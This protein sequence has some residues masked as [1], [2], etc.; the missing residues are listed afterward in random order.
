MANYATAVL[1]KGQTLVS[2]KYQDPENRRKNPTVFEMSLRNYEASIT[3]ANDLRNAPTRPV[4]ISYQ[5]NIAAGNATAKAALHT[6]NYGDANK[7]TLVYITHVETFQIPAKLADGNF[8][9][10]QQMFNNMYEMHWKNLRTRQDSSALAYLISN[11]CQ[12]DATTISNQIASAN[13]GAWNATNYALE[14]DQSRKARFA[15]MAQM[16]MAARYFT[17][18]YDVVADLQ[19]A[20]EFQFQQMQGAGNY[21]NTSWQFGGMTIGTTQD[22]ISSAYA[23]GASLWMPKGT[24]VGLDWNEALNK[25]GISEGRGPIGTVGVQADPLGSGAKADISMY[26]VRQDT[27]ANTTGG[28]VQDFVDQWE[29][30]LTMAYACPPLSLAGDSVIHLIAQ[31]Q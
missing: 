18:E 5:V 6:G 29:L 1:A 24:F 28:S 21:Q 25:R 2:N 9:S 26:T 22:T 3:E 11:R 17:G 16:F 19:T 7:F 23:Y 4:E 15:Q 13:P 30:S 8:L 27:S 10:Y 31:A 14:I 12:L 20:G